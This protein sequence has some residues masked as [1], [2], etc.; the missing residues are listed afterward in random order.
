MTTGF[1]E[2]APDSGYGTNDWWNTVLQEMPMAQYYSARTPDSYAENF[3]SQS[4]R[5]QRYFQ[6]GYQDVYADYLGNVGTSMRQGQE[7]TSFMDY[8]KANDPWTA[9]YSSLP[10][11]SRGTTGM[12]TNPRTRF[13]Y[14]F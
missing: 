13:L 4:P 14:N 10:Q 6:Q 5:Q 7:P 3:A 11:T 9:R 1:S 8:L 12:Y 2:F